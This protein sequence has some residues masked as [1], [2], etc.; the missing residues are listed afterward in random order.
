MQVPRPPLEQQPIDVRRGAWSPAWATWFG[1][2]FAWATPTGSTGS[3]T[4]SLGTNCPASV[5]TA[6]YTWIEVTAPDGTLCVQPI[7]KK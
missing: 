6:P 3:G 2:L 1:L 7:W 5:L 4:A